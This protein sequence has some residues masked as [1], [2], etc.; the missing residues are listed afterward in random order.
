MPSMM[1]S[2]EIGRAMN[3]LQ[4]VIL[5]A[6]VA[7]VF[8]SIGAATKLLEHNSASIDELKGITTDLVKSQVLS[9]AN[10]QQHGRMLEDL[11][12]RIDRLEEN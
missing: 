8:M 2:Q 7:G 11:S 12:R 4:G 6:T 5:L 9:A 1:N 10:D 3:V